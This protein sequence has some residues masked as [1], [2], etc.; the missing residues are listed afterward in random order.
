MGPQLIG[1]SGQKVP[2]RFGP[3]GQMVQPIW[4]PLDKWSL[5][6]SVCPGVQAL[7]IQKYRDRIG[8]GPFVQEDQICWGQFVQGDRKSGTGSPGI[9]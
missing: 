1:P 7:G 9:K 2:N 4:F 5:E 6:Y 8:L 3:H